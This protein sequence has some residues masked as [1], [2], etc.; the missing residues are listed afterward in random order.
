MHRCIRGRRVLVQKFLDRPR[1]P[2]PDRAPFHI[3]S[4]EPLVGLYV[5]EDRGVLAVLLDEQVGGAVDVEVTG[6]GR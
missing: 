4:L 3:A 6:R 5:C 2:P 1:D